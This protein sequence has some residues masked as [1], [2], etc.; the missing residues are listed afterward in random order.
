MK[1]GESAT[2]E[3]PARGPKKRR[4]VTASRLIT[5]QSTPPSNNQTNHET[6]EHIPTAQITYHT[7]STFGGVCHHVKAFSYDAFHFFSVSA[8]KLGPNWKTC[9]SSSVVSRAISGHKNTSLFLRILPRGSTLRCMNHTRA[10][11]NACPFIT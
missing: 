11:Y 7:F 3:A 6:S 4:L 10:A 1:T 5:I 2:K 8:Y 9:S